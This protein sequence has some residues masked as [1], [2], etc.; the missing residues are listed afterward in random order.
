MVVREKMVVVAK[1]KCLKTKE[2]GGG[3]GGLE[4]VVREKIKDGG[5]WWPRES[6]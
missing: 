4:M 1:G 5:G 2:Q 6:V 3:E